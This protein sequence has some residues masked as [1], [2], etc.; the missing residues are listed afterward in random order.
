MIFLDLEATII[1]NIHKRDEIFEN[2]DFIKKEIQNRKDSLG[3]FSF[4]LQNEKDFNMFISEL[5][6]PIEKIFERNIDF[7]FISSNE[8]FKNLLQ[9]DGINIFDDED[10]MTFFGKNQKERSFELFCNF[11]LQKS[12]ILFDDTVSNK[13]IFDFLNNIEIEFKRVPNTIFT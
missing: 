2:I 5:K 7:V 3:I 10:A 4:A 6:K 12:A 1:E 8:N 11:E 9:K 13:K